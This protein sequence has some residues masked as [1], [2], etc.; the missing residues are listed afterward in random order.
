MKIQHN[1]ILTISI[2]KEQASKKSLLEIDFV[3][4]KIV[5]EM[6]GEK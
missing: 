4:M 2:I 3:I 5:K 6:Q 1:P